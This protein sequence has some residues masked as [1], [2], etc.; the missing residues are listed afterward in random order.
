MSDSSSTPAFVPLS[1]THITI[2]GLSQ[3]IPKP[4][5]PSRLSH[6][7]RSRSRSPARA[8]NNNNNNNN[9]NKSKSRSRTRH[10][11]SPSS[12]SDS[13]D[14][15][16]HSPA[17]HR[18]LHGPSSR[19]RSRS[20]S[21]TARRNTTPVVIIFRVPDFAKTFSFGMACEHIKTKAT[22]V[23]MTR[24]ECNDAFIRIAGP[25]HA[26]IDALFEL[27]RESKCTPSNHVDRCWYVELAL[28]RQTFGARFTPAM[29]CG[30]QKC[31]EQPAYVRAIFR[32][33]FPSELQQR[34]ERFI[35]TTQ[36][37]AETTNI[38]ATDSKDK[39]EPLKPIAEEATVP[40]LAKVP[41]AKVTHDVVLDALRIPLVTSA[42]PLIQSMIKGECTLRFLGRVSFT[43]TDQ[44]V[45]LEAENKDELSRLVDAMEVA[46]KL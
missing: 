10:N 1:A 40:A 8:N 9:N 35:L 11:R 45:Q 21:P 41:V 31:L 4:V 46:I 19:R 20:R 23:H 37:A 26:V 42:W 27:I 32:T 14:S 34:L 30:F 13:S 16:S 5:T 24:L 33:R 36:A 3:P 25:L 6:R 29:Q 43:S 12:S 38:A 28:T 15:K 39:A 7:S 22:E 17:R 18:R 44:R 2:P